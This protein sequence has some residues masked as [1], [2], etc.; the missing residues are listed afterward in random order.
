[1]REKTFY[2]VYCLLRICSHRGSQE[3]NNFP[4]DYPS[5]FEKCTSIP[6]SDR[7]L[8]FLW[9]GKAHDAPSVMMAHYDVVPVEEVNW[10]KPPF[11]GIIEDG[12]LWGRG[13]L[14]TK[15]TFNGVLSA[16][17]HL[18]DEGFVPEQDV[19]FAFSGGEE[20]SGP[21]AVRIVEWFE[22]QGIKPALVVDEGGAVVQDVFP[23]VKEPCGL[24]GIAEKGM[25]NLS[26]SVSS[27]VEYVV[28]GNRLANPNGRHSQ[29]LH[30]GQNI[31]RRFKFH[32]GKLGVDVYFS[33]I[34]NQF[35]L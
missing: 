7:A 2:I 22:K 17:N 20:V 5:V 26:F 9:P 35:R 6:L 8:L 21:G 33:A 27:G 12:I 10:E 15:V 18:I 31:S 13:T 23:G 25:I 28:G 16:A 14:D 11:D 1:M 34:C 30:F 19:Y 29:R 32:A 24:I 3:H 4:L